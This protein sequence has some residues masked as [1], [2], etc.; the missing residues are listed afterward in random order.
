MSYFGTFLC[1]KSVK[2][3][4]YFKN[5]RNFPSLNNNNA[6]TGIRP[7][8]ALSGFGPKFYAWGA[9]TGHTPAHAPQSRQR[10]ASSTYLPSSATEIAL[11]GHS[12][13]QVP[14]PIQV[15]LMMEYAISNTSV[16]INNDNIIFIIRF[17][18]ETW[19]SKCFS[20]LCFKNK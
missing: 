14:Q 9:S 4:L 6:L 20:G 13:S 17:R 3:P 10:S 12:A 1:K 15:S 8:N 2:L 5:R 19:C 18:F 7:M 11:T 16:I